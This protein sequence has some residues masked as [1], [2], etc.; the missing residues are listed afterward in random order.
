MNTPKEFWKS[1]ILKYAYPSWQGYGWKFTTF[2]NHQLN[3]KIYIIN[4]LPSDLWATKQLMQETTK[5]PKRPKGSQEDDLCM[6]EGP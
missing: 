3:Q 2:E 1:A 6:L 5:R 4:L